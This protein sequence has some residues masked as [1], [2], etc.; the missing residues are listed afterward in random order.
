MTCITRGRF[1][2]AWGAGPVTSLSFLFRAF[3]VA[4]MRRNI[5]AVAIRRD[6]GPDRG[7]GNTLFRRVSNTGKGRVDMGGRIA[8]G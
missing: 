4:A 1:V 3:G 8:I 5:R 6:G 7:A 2:V